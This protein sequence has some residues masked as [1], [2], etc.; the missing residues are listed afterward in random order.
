MT[1]NGD[2]TF[3]TDG[4]TTIEISVPDRGPD[5]ARDP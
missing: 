3:D 1:L 5:E 2:L 4:G